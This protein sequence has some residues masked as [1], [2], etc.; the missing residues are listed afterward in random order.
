MVPFTLYLTLLESFGLKLQHHI[1]EHQLCTHNMSSLRL[2]RAALR[3]RPTSIFSPVQRR[4]YADAI[5]D[6]IKLSLALPH[7]VCHLLVMRRLLQLGTLR[8]SRNP[9]AGVLL[10]LF[11]YRPSTSPPMCTFPTSEKSASALMQLQTADPGYLSVSKSTSQPSRARWASLLSMY[12]LSNNS[13][14]ASSRSSRR[15]VAANNSSVRF[16]LEYA[17]FRLR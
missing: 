1:E 16:A 15:A 8:A 2:S 14:P 10:T 12:P 6:K 4:G 17:S 3:A 5:S 11:V 7:Q 13:N 9:S